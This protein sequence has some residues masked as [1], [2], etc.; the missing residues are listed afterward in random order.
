M[1]LFTNEIKER[2]KMPELLNFYGLD[3]RRGRIKCP[4]HNG[5]HYNC[6][7]K[8][9]YIHCFVCGGS[10]DVINFVIKYFN[11]SFKEAISKL[12]NDFHLGLPIGERID[13]RKQI[14]ISRKAFQAKKKREKAQAE[15]QNL[16]NN[17]HSA[18]DEYVR[19]ERQMRENK[20]KTQNE[21]LSPLFIEAL[22]GL[23]TAEHRLNFA[24]LE[25]YKYE[26][27]NSCN[28]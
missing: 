24:E 6:G 15:R 25:L 22:Q 11:L 5:E 9:D 16:Q 8:D 19:L 12:N 10:A 23:S 20:P 2:L 28:T 18:L 4:L 14:E 13:R 1:N 3:V 17:Y 27:R 7:V 21:E 26:T